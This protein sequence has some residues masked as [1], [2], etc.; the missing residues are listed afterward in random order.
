MKYVLSLAAMCLFL[1]VGSVLPVQSQAT[2]GRYRALNCW[3]GECLTEV[4]EMDGGWTMSIHCEG[5]EN[6]HYFY[7]TGSYGGSVCGMTM[8]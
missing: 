2:G 6:P 8:E 1:F 3:N 5:D 7:G 4:L